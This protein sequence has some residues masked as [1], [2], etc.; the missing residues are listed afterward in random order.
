MDPVLHLCC[1]TGIHDTKVHDNG[2]QTDR[3]GGKAVKDKEKKKAKG[4]ERLCT[5]LQNW[6]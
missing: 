1:Y 5:P 3:L 2:M 4:V 6:H